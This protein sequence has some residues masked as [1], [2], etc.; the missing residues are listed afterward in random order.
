M[1]LWERPLGFTV[2]EL[3]VKII[4]E[5]CTGGSQTEMQAYG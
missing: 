3:H 2:F 1:I 5:M 4:T